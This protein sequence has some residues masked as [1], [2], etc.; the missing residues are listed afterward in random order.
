MLVYTLQHIC[1]IV[2]AATVVDWLIGDPPRIPH[3]VIL[4]GRLISWLERRLHPRGPQ[5]HGSPAPARQRVK[6]MILLLVTLGAA[7][8]V[9]WLL[10]RMCAAIH[11]SLGIAASVCLIASTIAVKGLGQAAEKVY[12]P[13]ASGDLA[14]AREACSHIVARDTSRLDRSEL[15][16]AAVETTAENI[17]DAYVSPI[18]W[19]LLGGAPLAML[20]RAANTLDSM[21][22]YRDGRYRYFGWASARFDDVM[23]YAPARITG[24]LLLWISA[25]DRR[26]SGRR[27]FLSVRRFARLHPSPN[28]G[29]PEA[30]VAGALGVQLGGVNVYSGVASERARMGWPL[31]ALE[32]QDIRSAVRMLMHCRYWV[33]GGV[34]VCW[35]V[36]TFA[37]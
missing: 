4:L 19:A 5:P 31:R 16:R 33:T 23:N 6:G 26:L 28:S 2:I 24:M 11:P 20:Y 22:G 8:A 18:F 30:A 29:I 25:L 9:S 32:P 34:A 21:V 15:T 13:L 35:A 3:P 14:S 1:L 12:K 10:I 27:A 7:Y 37:I 17:V 36:V